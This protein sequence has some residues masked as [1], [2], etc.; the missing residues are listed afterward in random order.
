MK[1]KKRLVA[2]LNKLY[3]ELLKE[4]PPEDYIIVDQT[5]YEGVKTGIQYIIDKKNI[6]I[7]KR[8]RGWDGTS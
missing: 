3:L 6:E 1:N 8:R 7:K 2:Y 4:T 5:T